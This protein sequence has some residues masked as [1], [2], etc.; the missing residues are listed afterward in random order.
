ML[1]PGLVHD[2]LTPFE[3]KKYIVFLLLLPLYQLSYAQKVTEKEVP[4]NIVSIAKAKS[5]GHPVSMW[6]RDPN[7]NKY[8]A[9]ILS[10]PTV[11]LIEVS[12]KGEWLATQ[13]ALQEESFPAAPMKTIRDKYL[14]NGYEGSNYIFVEEP[15][16]AYYLVDVS[17]DD[18]DLEIML[19]TNGKILKAEAR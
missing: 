16:R 11:M 18:E 2:D 1:Q 7:R 13:N 8:I 15:G 17:S 10:E 4:S 6:V 5:K 12:M 19:D 3:M 9:T 14:S